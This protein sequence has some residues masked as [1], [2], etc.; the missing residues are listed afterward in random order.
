MCV[1]V[2]WVKYLLEYDLQIIDKTKNWPIKKKASL[3]YVKLEWF[4]ICP[5]DL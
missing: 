4:K 2:C 5:L 3:N 1:H